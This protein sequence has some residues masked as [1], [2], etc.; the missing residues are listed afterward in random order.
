MFEILKK[1]F[2]EF[3]SSFSYLR[4]MFL[5][6]L[7]IV[8]FLFIFRP[9]GFHEVRSNLFLICLGFGLMTI[10]GSLFFEFILRPLFGW[11]RTGRSFTFARW[12]LHTIVLL[13]CISVA[14]FIFLSLVINKQFQ[15]Q[16]FPSM[17]FG[18]CA[19]GIFPTVV[20][21]GLALIKK[22]KDYQQMA[23]A[24]NQ[25]AVPSNST[26][27][28]SHSV[29]IFGI[30]ASKIKYVEAMQNY[31]K[32]GFLS[33]QGE[34]EEQTERATLKAVLDQL[35]GGNIIKCHRSFLV[36]KESIISSS[37]NAQGL[38]MTLSDCEKQIPV[39]RS[40][41]SKFK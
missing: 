18:T 7:F 16:N 6:S 17:L 4:A 20:F 23:K 9:F 11:S 14:N 15:W 35:E 28:P 29:E 26:L 13:L 3:E 10:V 8:F 21:G 2:P 31:V 12:I 40:Y 19:I 32:I 24:I 27:L 38:L 25:K 37:G 36:N 34:L 22:E 30:K 41:V 33:N 5:V 1:P 39:S